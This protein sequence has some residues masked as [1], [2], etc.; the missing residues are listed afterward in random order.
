MPCVG[1]TRTFDELRGAGSGWCTSL[2]YW[3]GPYSGKLDSNLILE[4]AGAMSFQYDFEEQAESYG[5]ALPED[6]AWTN[7]FAPVAPV[8]LAAGWSPLPRAVEV[9]GEPPVEAVED[10]TGTRMA[11]A[12]WDAARVSGIDT[13]A[14]HSANADEKRFLGFLA[15][16]VMRAQQSRQGLLIVAQPGWSYEHVHGISKTTARLMRKAGFVVTTRRP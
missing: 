2:A 8:Q 7:V 1:T 14:R 11:V 5:G 16:T 3:L 4:V 12:A 13:T 9:L 15:V 6:Q 10:G